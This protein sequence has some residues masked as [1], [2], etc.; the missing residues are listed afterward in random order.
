MTA[1]EWPKFRIAVITVGLCLGGAHARAQAPQAGSAPQ[2]ASVLQPGPAGSMAAARARAAM[3]AQSAPGSAIGWQGGQAVSS[4][5]SPGMPSAPAASAV[6]ST[7]STARHSMLDE[8]ATPAQIQLSGDQL[9]ISATNASLSEVIR[10]VASKTGMQVEGNSRE[11]RVFG[12][13]GPGSPPDVLSA[14]LYDSGYNVMMVGSTQDG[15]PRR[16][17][18]STRSTNAANAGTAAP[19]RS[20]DED[21]DEPVAETPQPPPPPPTPAPSAGNNTAPGQPKTPQQMLEELQ[22]MHQGQQAPADAPHDPQ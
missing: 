4:K 21:D 12:V 18:L 20:S 5:P 6:G 15:A 9:S 2:T 14:L 17:V 8:P 7:T 3:A 22:R 1:S 16:L 19:V 11:E 13:Y 10:Q